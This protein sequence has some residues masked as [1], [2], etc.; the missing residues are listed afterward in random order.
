MIGE[1]IKTLRLSYKMSQTKLG[2][3]V[4]VSWQQIQKY[5]SGK[6]RVAATMLWK[7]ADIFGVQISYFISNTDIRA[8]A[9]GET[10]TT[11]PKAQV[12]KKLSNITRILGLLK[13][14]RCFHSLN[15]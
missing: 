15:R 8:G 2:N 10:D 12:E 9:D 7:I 5:E 1:R 4:G 14:R 13:N 6:N 11:L 3:E